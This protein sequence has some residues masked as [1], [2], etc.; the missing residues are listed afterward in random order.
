MFRQVW[1]QQVHLVL[2]E[3]IG[4]L[5][6]LEQDGNVEAIERDGVVRYRL[7]SLPPLV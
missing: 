4:H 3:V 7:V 2:S 6:L 1:R 5:D